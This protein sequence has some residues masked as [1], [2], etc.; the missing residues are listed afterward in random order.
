MKNKIFKK[1]F[2]DN[3]KSFSKILLMNVIYFGIIAAIT[4]FAVSSG[5]TGYGGVMIM[6]YIFISMAI[7]I[8]IYAVV[9]V[10]ISKKVIW[11]NILLLLSLIVYFTLGTYVSTNFNNPVESESFFSEIVTYMFISFV[12]T[13]VSTIISATTNP[14][15]KTYFFE[16]EQENEE[17]E[18]LD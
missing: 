15:H 5:G 18:T 1:V 7:Y 3:E 14:H 8:P 12:I 2:S 9:S 13:L 17:T 16:K 4:L 6:L 10:K 11:P